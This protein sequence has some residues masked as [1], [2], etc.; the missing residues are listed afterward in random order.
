MTR[1]VVLCPF[2]THIEPLCERGLR[3]AETAGFEVRRYAATAAVD[4]T[5]ADAAT[6]ALADGA[7][8]LV[9]VDSDVAFTVDELRALCG[10]GAP[11]IGGLYPKK[12]V[13]DFAAHF[14]PETR[15][16]GVGDAGSVF[17]VRY[18]GAGF[19][20]VAR[21]VFDDV[22]RHFGLPVCNTR[23]GAATVPYFL[24]MVVPD[25]D[26]PPG[27]YWYLGEDY[28]FCERARQAGH[29]VL[30]D[31]TLRLGHVG[32]YAYGWEDAGT[33]VP[34]VTGARFRLGGDGA[35]VAPIGSPPASLVSPVGTE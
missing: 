11:L 29:R 16:F 32:S 4:R 8:A 15:E 28:A 13:R 26:G 33:A 2:L 9:W 30:V 6:A 22:R 7:D 24:P 12:G 5:R 17:E 20:H 31:S 19:L 25:R 18:L 14:L 1:V 10:H 23:F 3:A 21:A 35:T 27:S 34:R